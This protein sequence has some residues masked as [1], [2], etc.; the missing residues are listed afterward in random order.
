MEIK[1]YELLQSCGVTSEQTTKK[2]ADMVSTFDEMYEQYEAVSA[3]LSEAEDNEE[4][5]IRLEEIKELES[6]MEDLDVE[7]IKSINTWYKNKD[8]W[9]KGQK[10]L[11]DKRAAK[12]AGLTTDQTA[13][14]VE[15]QPIPV[16]QPMSVGADGQ[17]NGLPNNSD[18][19][20]DGGVVK[21][22]SSGAWWILAGIIGIVTLGAVVMKKE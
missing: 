4:R 7:L 14:P 19:K 22:K 17:M 20:G 2:I 21:K 16:A 8:V 5:E 15:P 9:A 1:F 10:A 3:D 13:N 18:F 11:A 12:K 6:R